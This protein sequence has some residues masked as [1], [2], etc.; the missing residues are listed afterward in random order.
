MAR[1]DAKLAES[2]LPATDGQMKVAKGLGI[3]VAKLTQ[4]QARLLLASKQQ[5]NGA[6]KKNAPIKDS[7]TTAIQILARKLKLQIDMPS[8]AS[9]AS[10]L[11]VELQAK[12]RVAKSET[13]TSSGQVRVIENLKRL[14]GVDTEIPSNGVQARGVIRNLQAQIASKSALA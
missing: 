2:Q 1:Q 12:A 3:D 11:L 14:L 7:Q 8:I 4:G 6:D 5:S 9:D 10:A 13:I